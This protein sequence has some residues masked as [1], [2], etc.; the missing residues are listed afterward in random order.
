MRSGA[1]R[2]AKARIRDAAIS[3]IA[4]H[5]VADTTA[6]K[7]AE[8]AGVSPGLV[9]HHFGSMEALREACDDYVADT[10]RASKE[11]AMAE[12]PNL[13]V[14][15]ALREVGSEPFGAYLAEVLVEDSPAVV[16]L[17][18]ELVADAEQYLQQG[19]D[20]GM[21]R[22]TSN[23]RARAVTLMIWGLGTFVLHR[24]VERLLG[25]DL[26]DPAAMR[27]PTFAAYA[28]PVYELYGNG[29]LT[30]AAAANMQAAIAGIARTPD[31]TIEAEG[32][33]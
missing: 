17:V 9:I 21:I 24:H 22:P 12:G 13:D 30:D 33:T 10:I 20:A 7:V 31:P 4:E 15:A 3:C 1:D 18:D 5:G 14:L 25:V 8:I 27:S 23:P 11:K 6:R 29:F 26:T 32:T 16:R 19:V 28:A 2:T